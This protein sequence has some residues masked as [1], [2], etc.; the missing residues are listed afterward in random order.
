[1]N[2]IES[3]QSVSR[4]Q[5]G[6]MS[7]FSFL[8]SCFEVFGAFRSVSRRTKLVGGEGMIL[9]SSACLASNLPSVISDNY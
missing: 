7:G 2:R 6:Q 4:S 9:T 5:R 3:I 8:S 1:M